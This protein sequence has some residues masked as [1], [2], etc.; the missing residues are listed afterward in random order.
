MNLSTSTVDDANVNGCPAAFKVFASNIYTIVGTGGTGKVLT[1][2][3]QFAGN[4]PWAADTAT[5]TPTD[6]DS[7]FSDLALFN[8]EMY[9]ARSS[10]AISYLNAAGTAWTSLA[11]GGGGSNAQSLCTYGSKLYNGFN[12]TITSID[13]SHTVATGVLVVPDNG[14]II[15]FLKSAS[16]RIWIGTLNTNYGKG[17]VYEWDGNATQVGKSYRLESAGALSCVIKDDIPWITDA[18]GALLYWNG[19]TFVKATGL[20][21]V[22][23]KVL[24][25]SL[26][27][28]NNRFIHPNGM[29]VIKGKINLLINGTNIDTTVEE[30]I[31]SGIY[32]Y[33]ETRG[34]IHKNGIATAKAAATITD[35]AQ[36]RLSTVGALS[37]IYIPKAYTSSQDGSFLAGASYYTDATTVKSAIFSDDVRDIYQKYGYIITAK[38]PAQQ[39]KDGFSVQNMW[40]KIYLLYRNLL[41]ANDKLVVKYRILQADPVEATI[42]WTSTTTFTVANSSVVVSNYWTSGTGGEVEI[43]NGVGAG[44]CSHITNAVLSAGT[45]TV[46]VDET[47]TSAT[48]TAIARFQSWIKLPPVVT[49]DVNTSSENSIQVPANWI[50][51]KLCMTFTGKDEIEN[52]FI[53]NAEHLPAK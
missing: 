36:T 29:A 47:Y 38:L 52:L 42:T 19:G 51:F 28:A 46:T 43:Q 48:G 15:T 22:H 4:T 37:E 1:V 7:N 25:T 10:S 5:T 44:K 35:Y 26:A 31:P 8:G 27:A 32:E 40:Q 13:T 14:C 16:N 39:S 41:N 11:S 24:G 49:Q 53:I 9:A 21:R 17:F 23:E 2:S 50:Q 45:W 30:T 33:D 34:L 12:N 20:N 6:C 18:N 3:A